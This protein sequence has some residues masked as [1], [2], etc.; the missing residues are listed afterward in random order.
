M[1]II[2]R[3]VIC[4]VMLLS[5][6][7]ISVACERPFEN[8]STVE[9][10]YKH[11]WSKCV[12][13]SMDA[14]KTDLDYE[15]ILEKNGKGTYVHSGMKSPIKWEYDDETDEFVITGRIIKFELRGAATGETLHLY[16]GDPTKGLTVEYMYKKVQ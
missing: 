2:T 16:D 8:G 1:K 15:I 12:M 11:E 6:V 7:L 10:T 9:G 5:L 13:Y 4:A 3:I 14:A